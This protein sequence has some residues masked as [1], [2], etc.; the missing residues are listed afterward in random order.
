ME[1]TVSIPK[2]NMKKSPRLDKGSNK[3]HIKFVLSHICEESSLN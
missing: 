3:L 1:V 2:Q